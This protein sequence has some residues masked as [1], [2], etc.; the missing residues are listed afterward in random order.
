MSEDERVQKTRASRLLLHAQSL[1]FEYKGILYNIES[2]FEAKK[3]FY[4]F[5]R[6]G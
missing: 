1:S 5:C 4:E 3:E 6:K 2:T